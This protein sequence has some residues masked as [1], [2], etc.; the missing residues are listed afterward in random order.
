MLSIPGESGGPL[1]KHPGPDD[2]QTEILSY[3]RDNLGKGRPLRIAIAGGVGP[4]KS[5]LL[6]WIV[7]WGMATC[8]DTRCRVTA[9]TGAQIS[10]ATWP[11]ITKW[12]RLS[13]FAHEFEAGDR[14]LRSVNSAHKDWRC[15]ALTWDANNPEAFA[16]FHNS[17]SRI[18]YG[19]DESAGIAESIFREA[20]GIL[21]GA[22]DTEI[23][24][25]CLGNPTR[26]DTTFRTFFAGGKNAH[27]WKSWHI[28]TR[29]SRMADKRQIEEWITSYGIDSDFVRVRVLSQFPRTGNVSFI[30]PELVNEAVHRE[31]EATRYDPI[32]M[33]VDVARFGDDQTVLFLRRGLDAKSI[34]PVKLRGKDTQEVAAFV[35]DMALK[36][37][38]DAIFVDGGAM[39]P[40]VIDRLRHLRFTNVH[41]INFGSKPVRSQVG[42]DAAISTYF[43]RRAEMHG[44]MKEWLRHGAIPNDP[45]LVSDLTNLQYSYR[46]SEG[47]DCIILEKKEDMKARG[48]RIADCSDA[49]ALT[50][51][52]PVEKSNHSLTYGAGDNLSTKSNTIRSRVD[53]ATMSQPALPR[54]W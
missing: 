11:E 3:I 24:W 36:Y 35:A 12:H 19:F 5:A 39:G 9:N 18:I 33:G 37:E 32:V 44:L 7:N 6:A 45:E 29:T 20:E 17:G 23:I 46:M 14:R 21:S 13:L 2:W 51:A 8:V 25:L 4:G 53:D 54:T 49:L 26:T 22:E 38:V 40:G 30:S 34:P 42:D 41:D 15:D 50:F 10:T 52:L 47:R 16:G 28:D 48:L 43:N 27:L 1:A 31:V